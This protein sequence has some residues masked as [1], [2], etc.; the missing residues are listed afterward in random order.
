MVHRHQTKG[1]T[2]IELLVVISIIS[3][4]SS[5]V[6][7]SVSSAR[8]K[9]RDARRQIDMDQI[10]KALAIFYNEYGCLPVTN[11][12]T[13]CAGAIG[14]SDANSGTWD[15]S[16]QPIAT[17]NFMSFLVSSGLFNGKVPTDPIN[18]MTG[19]ETPNQFA[20]RYFC[21][22]PGLHLGYWKE[23][24]GRTYVKKN[25]GV[26]SDTTFVCK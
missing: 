9:A 26:W 16:S 14:Y 11:G 24:G 1:F 22:S 5:V 25:I 20:Y 18:N 3:L 10:Y 2:L 12:G 6:Y 13:T 21:Y 4:L 7:S 17:P 23:S 19:D 8:A 15:Y